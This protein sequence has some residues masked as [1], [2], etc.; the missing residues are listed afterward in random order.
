MAATNPSADAPTNLDPMIATITRVRDDLRSLKAAQSI[1][2]NLIAVV[3]QEE[4]LALW[5]RPVKTFIPVLALRASR[6]R[7][8]PDASIA[9]TSLVHTPAE[10]V[11]VT[12]SDQPIEESGMDM[13]RDVLDLSN[14]VQTID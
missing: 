9:P 5:P 4:V 3:A 10:P 13:S 12:A 7:L 1:D 14:D 11:L 2:P 6:T 8:F